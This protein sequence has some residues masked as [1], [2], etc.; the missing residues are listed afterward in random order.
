MSRLHKKTLNKS[1]QQMLQYNFIVIYRKGVA[2]G[3]PD[4]LS[5]S[6]VDSIS[7]PQDNVKQMQQ[8]NTF[9][10]MIIDYLAEGW[11]PTLGVDAKKV[12]QEIRIGDMVLVSYPMDYPQWKTRLTCTSICWCPLFSMETALKQS[13]SNRST[14]C[15]SS[16]MMTC[17]WLGNQLISD[18]LRVLH[19]RLEASCLGS[20]FGNLP[21]K[22]MSL[23]LLTNVSK[24]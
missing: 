14:I 4:T 3:G 19:R 23:C 7:M 13:P 18:G 22:A 1:Q 5:C 16:L 20:L 12:I 2:N 21:D 15:C 6:P 9:L 8:E 11:I 10:K 24:E 17:H